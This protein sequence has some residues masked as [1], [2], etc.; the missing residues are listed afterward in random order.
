MKKLFDLF[1]STLGI[2]VLLPLIILLAIIVAIESKGGFIYIQKRVGKNGIIFN[3]LKFRTMYINSDK[4]GLLTVGNRDP[5]ITKSGYYLRKYKLDELLQLFNVLIGDMSFVGPRP[6]VEKYVDLYTLNQRKIL[7]V[8][9]GI[10]DIASIAYR[11]ENQ[12]LSIQKNP[13]LFYIQKI[14]PHKIRLNMVYLNNQNICYDFKIV[15][16]TIFNI[17][18]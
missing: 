11:S 12:I 1:F 6:E 15:F 10:T 13:E 9:P 8:K 2:I 16:L 18:K 5:R 14:M 17:F 3:L 4:M 7:N